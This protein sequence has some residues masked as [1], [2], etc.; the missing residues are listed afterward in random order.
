[1]RLRKLVKQGVLPPQDVSIA[2]FT[3]EE[4]K[5]KGGLTFPAVVVRNLDINADGSLTKGL[6]MEFF[7]ADVLEALDM[8]RV[9][10]Q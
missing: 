6:P 1:L 10:E 2:Y 3:I 9:S 7:G 8:E 4:V 5:R